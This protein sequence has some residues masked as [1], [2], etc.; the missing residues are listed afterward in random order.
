MDLSEQLETHITVCLDKDHDLETLKAFGENHQ[1]KCLHIV[2]DR[3][4]TASQPMLSRR[5]SQSLPIE[6]AAA[7]DLCQK[8]AALGF[9]A[10]GGGR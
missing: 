9:R 6:L 10:F 1:L 4:Q 2:L 3:G 7:H 5:G 8:L